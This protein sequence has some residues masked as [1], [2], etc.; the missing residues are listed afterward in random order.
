MFTA[1]VTPTFRP[2]ASLTITFLMMLGTAIAEPVAYWSFDIDARDEGGFHNGALVGSAAITTGNQGFGGAGEALA[3]SGTNSYM[4]AGNPTALNFG[5]DF[6]WHAYIQTSDVSGTIFSR[7]PSGTAWNQGSKALFVRSNNVTWDTGWVGAPG[8]GT[9]VNDGQWHQVIATYEANSDL[10]NIFID[11][12]AGAT[13]GQYSGT[14]DVN[15]FDEST[16]HNG[17]AANT[18]FTI[19]QANFSGGLN[20]LDT[21]LGL[22]DEAAVFNNALA[23]AELDQLITQG[24]ASFFGPVDPPDPTGDHPFISELVAIGNTSKEDEDGDTPDWLEI[25]NP[26]GADLDLAGYHLTDDL[27]NL[28]KWTFPTTILQ[29]GRHLILFASDKNRATEGSELHLNFKLSSGGDYLALVE[30]DGTTI[31]SAFSP[32]FPAQVA[33]FSY[34]IGGLSP[35]DSAGYFASPSPGS[36]NGTLL[37][38]PLVAPVFDPPCDTFTTS[39]LVTITPA[40]PGAEIRYTTNGSIPTSASAL[41]SA[42]I[43]LSTTT[44]LRARVFDATTGGGGELASGSFQKLATSSNL[45]GIN[46]PSTFTSDLPIMV[47]ENFGAGGIPGPGA[48]LQTAR[49]SVFEPD[50]VTGRSSISAN[51]DACFRI[52]IRKRGQSSSGFSKPQYRVELRDESDVDLDYPL[53]GLPSESDWVFNGPWTDKAL[54]RNSFSFDLGREIGVEAPR[55][56]HFEMF[57][58]TGGTELTSSEYVG[59]YVLFE[60]IKQGKNRTDITEMSATD[61]SDPEVTG[62]YMMR[63]EPPGIANDGPRATGWNTV[64]ILEPGSPTT[65]QRDYLG[66]YYDDFV[67]TLGWSRGS[68]A[69]NSGVVNPDPVTGYPAFIDVDS[70]VN[71]FII[72]ELGRDQDAYVRSDYMFKDRSGK[73]NKGPLW[74]HNLIMG[75]GCCFDNRNP[76][77]WQ[78]QDNYNRGGRDHSYEPDWFVPL[79]RDPDFRQKVIDRWTELRRDGALEIGNL[80]ARLDAQASPLSEAAVRNFTKWNTLGSGSVG[81]PTPATS[82]WEQQIEFIQDWL[83][84]RMTW[85]DGEYPKAVTISPSSTALA[86]GTNVALNAL[87][88][89]V[90]YTLNG[91]DPRLPGGG[92]SLDALML[93]SSGNNETTLIAENATGVTALRPSSSSPGPTAWTATNFDTTGWQTGSNGVGY[94]NSPADFNGLINIPVGNIAGQHPHSVYIRIPFNVVD[95]SAYNV[96]TLRMKYDDGFVA[97]LNGVRVQSENAP[98]S[99]PAWNQAATNDHPDSAAVNFVDFDISAYLGELQAGPNVLAIHALN[100]GGTP[101]AT[102]SS[103]TSSDMLAVAELIAA[104][105]RPGGSTVTINNTTDLVAR[106]FDGTDW[107]GPSVETFV[108]GIP[109][110]AANLAITELNYHPSNPTPSELLIDPTFSDDDFEFIEVKNVSVEPIDLSGMTFSDGINLTIPA[111]TVLQSGTYGLFVTNQAAFEQRWGTGLP[112]LGIYTGRLNNDGEALRLIDLNG[113]DILNFTFNDTWYRPTDGDGYTL[114]PVNENDLSANRNAPA[115]WGISCEIQGTPGTSNGTAISQTFEGWLNY[116]FSAAEQANPLISGPF[117]DYDNDGFGTLMEF[118]L[119]LKPNQSDGGDFLRGETVELGDDSYLAITFRRQKKSL[120]L[121]YSVELS[122]NLSNWT[123]GA[124]MVGTAIDNGDGSE[125]VTYRDFVRISDHRHRAMRLKVSNTTPSQL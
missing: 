101:N 64:E 53:L 70:F 75:T 31:I 12:V 26:T 27:G 5:S 66:Q 45:A 79:M 37:N 43:L 38:A 2:L 8:T 30:P 62:G 20:N 34:G 80:F 41:Y 107:G 13:T 122:S 50:P 111:T 94:E 106:S 32:T 52:G 82:T 55:T 118:A 73:L 74:D 33:G 105:V 112:I 61:N 87:G 16:T 119:A 19:G 99:T 28:T 117:A 104:D 116:H 72:T 100:N 124:V 113:N 91:S 85:I 3:I 39:T 17:G 60:K 103:S 24:P 51:P 9:A 88:G 25:Y 36:N 77:G 42:P 29:A 23:G 84:Q 7:N 97:Y 21:L 96:L 93:G 40:F 48:T 121:V 114:V 22:I 65:Q 109:A 56:K 89:T 92:I 6:T 35:G 44:H 46:P 95:P 14:H 49:V 10:L 71:H 98:T 63:F 120:N 123:A 15:R 90:Y 58:S 86:A 69:N 67:A 18:S 108:V 115:S 57:L 1:P 102:N 4:S 11:P 110:S 54:V 76:I 83:V 59:V 81:F 68:G 47:V 78:F 125:T